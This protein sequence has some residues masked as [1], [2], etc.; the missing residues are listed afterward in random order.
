MAQ[1]NVSGDAIQIKTSLTE[2]EFDMIE[3][4]APESLKLVDDNGN[5]Y[6]GITRGDA[7]YSKY[8]ISFCNTDSEGRLFMT[9][10]NPVND[11]SDPEKEKKQISK[12]LAQTINN[13]QTVE[14]QIEAKKPEIVALEQNADRVITMN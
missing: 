11:H 5:E 1:I 3:H 12:I 10:N 8:G 14:D 2:E 7:H 9:A 13:L 4:Y 6:F